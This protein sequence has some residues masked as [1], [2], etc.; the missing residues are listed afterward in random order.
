[1]VGELK[2]PSLFWW[3]SLPIWTVICSGA[4]YWAYFTTGVV[5]KKYL[6]ETGPALGIQWSLLAAFIG[7][8]QVMSVVIYRTIASRPDP[9]KSAGD[10]FMVVAN[11]ALNNWVQ[12][13]LH[14]VLNLIAYACHAPA[15]RVV[16]FAVTYT[17]SRFLYWVGYTQEA[18]TGTPG[19]FP[20]I[21]GLLLSLMMS[22]ENAM[23]ILGQ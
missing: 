19:R 6:A 4:V 18:Y 21:Y 14:F 9:L 20:V 3:V 1:M 13:T 11:K 12:Q 17:A 10:R 16:L 5:P 22:V 7:F 23:W 2:L 15:E 8:A